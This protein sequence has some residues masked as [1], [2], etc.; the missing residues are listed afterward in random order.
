MSEIIRDAFGGTT[1]ITSPEDTRRIRRLQALLQPDHN[2]TGSG[3]IG[4]RKDGSSVSYHRPCGGCELQRERVKKQYPELFPEPPP[5][6]VEVLR[7]RITKAVEQ[8][9]EEAHSIGCVCEKGYKCREHRLL[10]IATT[11]EGEPNGKSD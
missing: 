3:G 2:C 1:V 8:L 7:S 6:E 9:R 5:S 10:S 4:T 11:L